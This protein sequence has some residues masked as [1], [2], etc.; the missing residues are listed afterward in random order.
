MFKTLF[1]LFLSIV[2]LEI[3]RFTPKKNNLLMSFILDENNINTGYFELLETDNMK[4]Q[5]SIVSRDEKKIL[6]T[7][8]EDLVLNEKNRFS[9]NN[10]EVLDIVLKIYATVIDSSKSDGYALVEFKFDSGIDTF[11]QK[12]SKKF[13]YEPAIAALDQLLKQLEKITAIT[14]Q[15]YE[16]A[17]KLGRQQK[18]TLYFIVFISNVSFLVFA[19]MNIWHF[20]KMKSYLNKKKYL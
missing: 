14:K 17:G 10:T 16:H 7:T 13:Q 9:F 11:N 18:T 6:F 4:V 15:E 3:I 12:V 5:A 8:T 1:L 20:Y 19:A 2:K